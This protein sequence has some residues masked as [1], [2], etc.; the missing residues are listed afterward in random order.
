MSVI[1]EIKDS[2]IKVIEQITSLL[3]EQ[4][5]YKVVRGTNS[6]TT[7]LLSISLEKLIANMTNIE[8]GN[9]DFHFPIKKCWKVGDKILVSIDR[10]IVQKLEIN[11]NDPFLEE[12]PDDEGLLCVLKKAYEK[13]GDEESA[14]HYEE[15]INAL[16][17]LYECKL[18]EILSSEKEAFV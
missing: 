2:G 14:A 13:S 10:S 16:D 1:T 18:I 3:A 5:K 6:R 9:K 7:L 11:E 17:P 4:K 15:K 12:N 8:N